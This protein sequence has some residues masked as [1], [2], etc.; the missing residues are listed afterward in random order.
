MMNS[1]FD[2]C[3]SKNGKLKTLSNCYNSDNIPGKL[4]TNF[5]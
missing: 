4:K 1:E 2:Y 5:F 3:F